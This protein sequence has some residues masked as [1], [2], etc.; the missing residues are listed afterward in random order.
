MV[1]ASNPHRFIFEGI[2][3]LG[4][5][6]KNICKIIKTNRIKCEKFYGLE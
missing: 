5:S 1:M 3:I 6:G 4:T 2:D